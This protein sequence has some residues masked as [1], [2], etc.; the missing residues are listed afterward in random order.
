[1]SYKYYQEKVEEL[2][3]TIRGDFLF[4]IYK[5]GE[6]SSKYDFYVFKVNNNEVPSDCHINIVEIY[7]NG[8]I[9][10]D[11]LQYSFSTVSLNVLAELIDNI[12]NRNFNK[13]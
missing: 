1:M 10:N 3:S 7:N 13:Q 2:E 5:Y 4:L 8:F 6:P 9:D 11:G 12:K